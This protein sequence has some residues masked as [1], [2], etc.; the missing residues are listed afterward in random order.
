MQRTNNAPMESVTFLAS[1]LLLVLG[2]TAC[3]PGSSGPDRMDDQVPP[4]VEQLGPAVVAIDLSGS[5]IGGVEEVPQAHWY[6]TFWESSD[7]VSY[8]SDTI[9]I[10]GRIYRIVEGDQLMPIGLVRKY[11]RTYE[12]QFAEPKE[13]LERMI[14]IGDGTTGPATFPAGQTFTYC[15][16]RASFPSTSIYREIRRKLELA[17]TQWEG[18]CNVHFVHREDLDEVAN[19]SPGIGLTFVTRWLHRPDSTAAAYA[20][21]PSFASDR[22]L[23]FITPSYPGP[24]DSTGVFRHE[25]GH[26]MGFL[27]EHMRCASSDYCLESQVGMTPVTPCDHHSVM[28]YFCNGLGTRELAFTGLDSCG[29]R[30]LYPFPG[31]QPM[32]CLFVRG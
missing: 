21:Y 4:I 19:T 5:E 17:A 9:H 27:H 11:E 10:D 13:L 15:I 31:D 26:M 28:H 14:V 24:H 1:T 20:F 6:D 22:R 29:S 8:P 18:V 25:L 12:P 2:L 23:L 16:D 3:G 7:T 32:D 30:Q